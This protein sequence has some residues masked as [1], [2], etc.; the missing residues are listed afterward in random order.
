LSERMPR[1]PASG[2]RV[3]VQSH[4]PRLADFEI[5]GLGVYSYVSHLHRMRFFFILLALLSVSSLVA[6]GYGEELKEKQLNV[7][8]WLFTGASLGNA[9]EIAPSYGATELLISTL[10]TAFLFWSVAALNDDAHRVEQKQVT[11]ADF[12][13][14]ISDL[15]RDAT[16]TRV[17]EAIEAAPEIYGLHASIAVALYQRELVLAHRE[18]SAAEA[19]RD[20]YAQDIE[21]LNLARTRN[22]E[23]SAAGVARQEVLKTAQ[24]SADEACAQ[25]R[26][27]AEAAATTHGT[28]G[29]RCAGVAFVTFEDA[30]DSE[31]LLAQGQIALPGLGPGTFGVSRP[32]EPSDLIWENLGCTD[33]FGRQL[34][35]TLMMTLLSLGGAFLIGASAYLQPKEL[36]RGQ[37]SDLGVMVVGTA[38]LLVG[39]LVVFIT[40]PIV[41]VAFMRHTSVTQKEVSQVLKLVLFQVLA[42]LS[43]IGSFAADTA[44]SFNR[45][46]YI[47]GGFMLVNGMFV[48]LFVITCIIQGWGLVL[49]LGRLLAAPRALTQFEMDL[50]YSG[51]GGNMYVVDRLQLVTK[52]VVMCYICSAAI[53]L[54]HL[55]VLLVLA[56]SIAIDETN[57]LRRL[58][59]APQSDESV[60]K[61][62]LVFVMPLAVL[63]HLMAARVFFA[64]L[65]AP[66]D[67]A[68]ASDAPRTWHDYLLPS[69]R[70][71]SEAD[72]GLNFVS[73]SIWINAPLTLLF[74]AREWP[75]F[76]PA[77][78]AK[79]PPPTR[80][81]AS[82]TAAASSDATAT[83]ATTAAGSPEKVGGIGRGR[84]IIGR[85]IAGSVW[86]R[87]EEHEAGESSSNRAFDLS[88]SELVASYSRA[89]RAKEARYTPPDTAGVVAAAAAKSSNRR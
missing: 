7:V 4:G 35:G 60:V 77:T 27:A 81:P 80:P 54:L 38:V 39:Y 56:I 88:Y 64:Q 85:A 9:K 63:F 79:A 8:T 47:T 1:D 55:V 32:P 84:A 45:D 16:S 2:K 15:P 68:D 58:Y 25:L 75:R 57:L 51:D 82:D 12:S 14:M 71:G 87:L 30:H 83:T 48:D 70:F 52:F 66:S 50:A 6:N 46:W 76:G 10:M 33:G 61:C 42:T 29:P 53:P 36:E 86:T 31:A 89:G 67:A 18:L 3:G 34:C 44:G 28:G 13:V 17:R 21:R 22:G 20:A 62:I 24:S 73:W 40:V 37:H 26:A 23:L 74:I 43:T 78:S 19:K 59:P 5:L 65:R 49:N 72:D 11:P 69:L 41:E